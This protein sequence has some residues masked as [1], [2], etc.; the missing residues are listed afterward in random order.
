MRSRLDKAGMVWGWTGSSAL[1]ISSGGLPLC[2]LPLLEGKRCR[3]EAYACPE[4][5]GVPAED[6]PRNRI[7]VGTGAEFYARARECGE[8]R[9]PGDRRRK[10]WGAVGA[11][12]GD[13]RL[14]TFG[15]KDALTAGTVYRVVV[16]LLS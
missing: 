9:C 12:S 16:K 10:L 4:L 11:C 1:L 2:A 14:T 5:Q 13:L 8:F 6:L 3:V 7:D 15:G